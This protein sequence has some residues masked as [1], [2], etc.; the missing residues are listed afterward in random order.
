LKAFRKLLGKPRQITTI[1]QRETAPLARLLPGMQVSKVL[2]LTFRPGADFL[3]YILNINK[4]NP[5]VRQRQ[6]L[7]RAMSGSST[8]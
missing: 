4:L 3:Y 2:C 7:A 5:L 8:G 1:A 6:A